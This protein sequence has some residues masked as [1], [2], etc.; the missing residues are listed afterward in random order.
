MIALT[1]FEAPPGVLA[2]ISDKSPNFISL[3][4]VEFVILFGHLPKFWIWKYK[5]F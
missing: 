4:V 1:E 2:L 5:N 3:P